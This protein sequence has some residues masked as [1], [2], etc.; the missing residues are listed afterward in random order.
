MTLSNVYH[1][2][3]A[4]QPKSTNI[5]V[6]NKEFGEL[7]IDEQKVVFQHDHQGALRLTKRNNLKSRMKYEKNHHGQ[8]NA[9]SLK[10]AR[11]TTVVIF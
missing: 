2:V 1:I 5:C 3:S 10:K 6:L 11:I 9:H 8:K 4:G 7:I